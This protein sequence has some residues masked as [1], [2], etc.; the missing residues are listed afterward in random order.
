VHSLTLTTCLCLAS[1]RATVPRVQF[2]EPADEFDCSSDT[3]EGNHGGMVEH[4]RQLVP[5][6]AE[7]GCMTSSTRPRFLGDRYQSRFFWLIACKLF[8]RYSRVNKVCYEIGPSGFDDISVYYSKP[9]I[10]LETDMTVLQDHY[11]IKFHTTYSSAV[12]WQ[13]LSDP[14][15]INASSR[16]LLQRLQ[17]I[18][19]SDDLPQGAFRLY[20]VT[21]WHLLQGDPLSGLVSGIDGALI[22]DK[23]FDG[24]K[25]SVFARIR[26][27]WRDHLGLFND[28]ELRAVLSPLRLKVA[29]PSLG[30]LTSLL[31]T[32]LG[33]VGLK[34]IDPTL[35]IC[36]YD[37]LLRN[38]VESNRRE[39]DRDTL[40]ETCKR[41][42]L[43]VGLKDDRP[44]SWIG[45][46][47]FLRWAED[48][49]DKTESMLCLLDQFSGR[50]LAT[51]SSWDE[52]IKPRL[53]EFLDK[54][55]KPGQAYNLLLDAHF[56]IAFACGHMLGT[57]SGADVAP[58]QRGSR[59]VMIWRRDDTV[60]QDRPHL[61]WA[62]EV[63]NPSGGDVALAL[64]I[65][66]PIAE[67]VREFIRTNQ[68]PVG[69]LIH[70]T[71]D[72]GPGI[73]RIVDGNHAW[74]L[75]E[76]VSVEI[77]KRSPAE[78]LHDLHIF[79]SAP[80]GFSF[81]L[82]QIASGFGRCVLYEYDFEKNVAGGYERSLTL[83]G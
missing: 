77:K 14:G 35:R 38:L 27:T 3:S 47:S 57:K 5:S 31:S 41:E 83:G 53:S 17:Q 21:P 79:V 46:R 76:E 11:Q 75:A 49:E 32:S 74:Q 12:G 30:G 55:V 50:K 33:S 54:V 25:N 68:I 39:F 48:M 71:L 82:G 40:M 60:R 26:K 72:V 2:L 73:D 52:E 58:V 13:S 7:D 37:D 6:C 56:S 45:V 51:N 24:R 80:N 34:P 63:L 8:E 22:L 18:Q 1:F 65:S 19:R 70:G 44:A 78:R 66:H 36:P 64:S 15:F 23:L 67:D 69:R 16:S 43:W 59:G 20:F 9:V 4:Y 42:G 61:K 62:S 29:S 10:D 28:D 81:Y